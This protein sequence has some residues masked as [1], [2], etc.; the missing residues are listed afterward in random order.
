MMAGLVGLVRLNQIKL[1]DI[2]EIDK[3]EMR[4]I[5]EKGL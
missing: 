3:K 5:L 1:G 2:I 4:R